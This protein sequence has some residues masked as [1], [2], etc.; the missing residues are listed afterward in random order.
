MNRKKKF[1]VAHFSAAGTTAELAKNVANTRQ[2]QCERLQGRGALPAPSVVDGEPVPSVAGVGRLAQPVTG[3]EAP[4]RRGAEAVVVVQGARQ[5]RRHRL[6]VPA[7]QDEGV[8]AQVVEPVL[9]EVVVQGP[10]VVGRDVGADH[11]VVGIA[12]DEAVED[13][14]V[15]S[16]TSYS[17]V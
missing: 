16:E 11:A 3:Q 1:L 13:R 12:G 5:V 8:V 15:L 2:R 14:E 4:H 7:R 9:L 17:P 10:G 6:R